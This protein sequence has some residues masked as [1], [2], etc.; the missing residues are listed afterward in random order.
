[1]RGTPARGR[2]GLRPRRACRWNLSS[3]A[4]PPSQTSRQSCRLHSET[5]MTSA[6]ALSRQACAPHGPRVPPPPPLRARRRPPRA[7]GGLVRWAVA[8]RGEVLAD[9][10]VLRGRH[11]DELG[12]GSLLPHHHSVRIDPDQVGVRRLPERAVRPLPRPRWITTAS[13]APLR[14]TREGGPRAD[15]SGQQPVQNE[16]LVPGVRAGAPSQAS[17]AKSAARGKTPH[18]V[19]QR[20]TARRSGG[21]AAQTPLYPARRRSPHAAPAAARAGRDRGLHR[22]GREHL[23][24][25]GVAVAHAVRAVHGLAQPAEGVVGRVRHEEQDGGRRLR[26]RLRLL[27]RATAS[28]RAL[29]VDVSVIWT[30]TCIFPW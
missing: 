4:G 27:R 11:G 20:V 13:Q 24:A 1:M 9:D 26:L 5:R 12:Q 25:E 16:D 19:V 14:A 3:R 7:A 29:A 21:C 18:P 2:Q 30:Q 6:P 15:R 10:K 22:L 23:A 28:L 17:R 8:R